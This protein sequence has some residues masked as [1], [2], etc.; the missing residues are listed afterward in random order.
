MLEMELTSSGEWPV[1]ET[2]PGE[3]PEPLGMVGSEGTE[4][5][6]GCQIIGFITP[7]KSLR[8]RL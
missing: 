1:A 6:S 5:D 3:R 4:A 7:F 8:N 2:R